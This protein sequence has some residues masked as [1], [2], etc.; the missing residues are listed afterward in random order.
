M[1]KLG[2]DHDATV[3]RWRHAI[4]VLW[5]GELPLEGPD[6]DE[7]EYS[8]DTDEDDNTC[9]ETLF[10]SETG[11]VGTVYIVIFTKC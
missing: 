9:E 2:E 11:L 6:E 10:E 4:E 8:T 3:K 5:G 7:E 1:R